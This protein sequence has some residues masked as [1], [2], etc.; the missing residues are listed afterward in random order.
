MS[1][2]AILRPAALLLAAMLLAACAKPANVVQLLPDPDGHVGAVHVT[3]N[4]GATDLTGSGDAVR[5]RDA[6]SAPGPVE[7]L[8][9]AEAEKL[10]GPAERALP[11]RPV[12]FLLYFENDGTRLTPASRALLPQVL[13]TVRARFSRDIAVVGHASRQ[14]DERLNIELSRRRAEVVAA[15]LEKDGVTAADIEVTSHGSANPLV[16]SHRRNEPRNRR[17]EITVR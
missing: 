5:I 3:T 17:V 6:A 2:R 9:D 12:R 10:F 1:A 8:S 11:E 13:A 7:R 4:G 15:M 16:I 14:G